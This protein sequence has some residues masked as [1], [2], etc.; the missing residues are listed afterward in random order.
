VFLQYCM[1]LHIAIFG[2]A[3]CYTLVREGWLVD[4]GGWIGLALFSDLHNWIGSGGLRIVG[5]NMEKSKGEVE[6]IQPR[7]QVLSLAHRKFHPEYRG[8]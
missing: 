5:L 1:C 7:I 4:K 2:Q 8:G 6:E 3:L